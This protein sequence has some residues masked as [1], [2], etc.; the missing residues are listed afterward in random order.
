[1]N[2]SE[3]SDD[4]AKDQSIAMVQDTAGY[5]I[6]GS[7]TDG[8]VASI[9]TDGITANEVQECPDSD[10]R[11]SNDCASTS[12]D[13]P[14][15]NTREVPKSD[16]VTPE[17][18]PND[19]PRGALSFTENILSRESVPDLY[20]NLSDEYQHDPRSSLLLAKALSSA[21][22]SDDHL[23]DESSDIP[24]PSIFDNS[25]LARHSVHNVSQTEFEPSISEQQLYE[26]TDKVSRDR[27]RTQINAQAG[28]SSQH[29]RFHESVHLYDWESS[30]VVIGAT[31]SDE[32]CD[33]EVEGLNKPA[34]VEDTWRFHERS[35]DLF[36]SILVH[37]D[38]KI[39]RRV[40]EDIFVDIVLLSAVSQRDSETLS[41][42][43][44]YAGPWITRFPTFFEPAPY[45]MEVSLFVCWA[46]GLADDFKAQTAIIWKQATSYLERLPCPISE[47]LEQKRT[48][49]Q[50]LYRDAVKYL[51]SD[52]AKENQEIRSLSGALVDDMMGHFLSQCTK[53]GFLI[54][55]SHQCEIDDEGEQVSFDELRRN[56]ESIEDLDNYFISAQSPLASAAQLVTSVLGSALPI[57]RPPTAPRHAVYLDNSVR[58]DLQA[59]IDGIGQGD[60][61]LDLDQFRDV[62]LDADMLCRIQSL[63]FAMYPHKR[64]NMES[65]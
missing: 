62:T 50:A 56:I 20:F 32:G 18:Y 43:A 22:E 34:H 3:L 10:D 45:H 61:G 49:A 33:S 23:P 63:L 55:K 9:S 30:S 47:A 15:P 41:S 11:T 8:P 25:S 36:H 16:I 5:M 48:A 12:V 1:M 7:L 24:S 35:H 21:S 26:A 65:E 13:L 46:L 27:P 51:V 19:D 17:A 2:G 6:G 39:P 28:I 60:C 4:A 58:T 44:K 14:I 29:Q 64:R 37:A 31:K 38:D 53:L 52:Y 57:P 54:R 59:I 40:S 42:V